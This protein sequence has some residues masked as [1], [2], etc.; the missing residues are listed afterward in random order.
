[1]TLAQ[2]GQEAVDQVLAAQTVN[3]DAQP[4]PGR[5]FDLVLMD[6]QMPVMD[7]YEAT[8]QLR[9]Q[10]YGGPILALTAHAMPQDIQQCLDAGCNSHLSKPIDRETLL[11][12]IARFLQPSAARD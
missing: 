9:K 7:G 6:I 8:R 11:R 1:M 5:P 2:N 3:P 4:G 10:G 12:T